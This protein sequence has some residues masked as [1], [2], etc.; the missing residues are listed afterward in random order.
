MTDTN[1]KNI[2]H[3]NRSNFAF[4]QILSKKNQDSLWLN[5]LF[6]CLYKTAIHSQRAD[7]LFKQNCLRNFNHAYLIC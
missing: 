6:M 2:K 1:L 3:I 4:V 7:N 5:W